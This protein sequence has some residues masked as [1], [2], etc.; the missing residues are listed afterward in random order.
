MNHSVLEISFKSFHFISTFSGHEAFAS[1]VD[2]A[3]QQPL[4]PV[5]HKEEKRSNNVPVSEAA[6]HHEIRYHPHL[7]KFCK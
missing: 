4:L 1:L 7:G 3:V 2:V 6:Q 5:P